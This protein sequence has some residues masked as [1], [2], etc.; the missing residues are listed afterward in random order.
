MKLTDIFERVVVLNLPFRTDRR[1][2]LERHLEE[3]EIADVSRIRWERAVCGD[4][5]KPSAWWG[6]GGGAWGCLLSHVRVVQDAV[7]DKIEAF[8]VLEDDV[9]FH[10]HSAEWLSLFIGDLP[11]DWGQVY[12]G[13]QHRGRLEEVPGHPFVVRPLS[14]NRTHC[15]ALR[16]TAFDAFHR[17]VL[18]FPDYCADVASLATNHFHIDHQLERAHQRRTWPV[19]APPWWIAGQEAGD[20]NISGRVNPRKWWHPDGQSH[21]LPFIVVPPDWE[22]DGR[23]DWLHLGFNLMPRT[24]YDIGLER[25][26]GSPAMLKEWADCVA[27]EAVSLWRLPAACHPSLTV[28]RM[29]EVWPSGALDLAAV[30]AAALR[31]LADYPANGLFPSPFRAS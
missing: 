17:H 16:D 20:S 29:R 7:A 9:V 14:V 11:A 5:L 22:P 13:G 1:E 18:Y 19:Y 4:W 6:A 8:C 24:L 26:V 23:I 10:E 21:V 2:R 25:A 28:E 15:F 12:L 27:S 31:Q 30:P 3:M